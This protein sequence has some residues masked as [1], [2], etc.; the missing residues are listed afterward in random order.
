MNLQSSG[1]LSRDQRDESLI[2]ELLIEN[3]T[4]RCRLKAAKETI[5]QFESGEKYL[6]MKSEY[7]KMLGHEEAKMR[8]LEQELANAHARNVTI[9]N[10]WSEIFDD[11]EKEQMYG[12]SFGVQVPSAVLFQH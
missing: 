12:G 8:K 4:L 9:R 5:A 3:N 10:S 1:E 11:L 6:R 2:G 7:R